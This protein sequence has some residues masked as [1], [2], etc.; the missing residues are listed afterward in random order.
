MVQN[1]AKEI[2]FEAWDTNLQLTLW[3][4]QSSIEWLWCASSP[5]WVAEGVREG[6]ED[7]GLVFYSRRWILQFLEEYLVCA[8]WSTSEVLS[9][10]YWVSYNPEYYVG[11]LLTKI[12]R[13]LKI[14]KSYFCKNNHPEKIPFLPVNLLITVAYS[15]PCQ[16][17]L[18]GEGNK[19]CTGW[20]F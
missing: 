4:F 2:W 7:W 12:L 16:I 13:S 19:I 14:L 11:N 18:K 1:F 17:Y 3:T 20:A 8:S 10:W 15:K 9:Y 5:C 6:F